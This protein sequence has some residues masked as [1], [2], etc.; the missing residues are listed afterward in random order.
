MSNGFRFITEEIVAEIETDSKIFL[1]PIPIENFSQP[2]P[3]ELF[4]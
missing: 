3:I 4:L 2:K 1:Q